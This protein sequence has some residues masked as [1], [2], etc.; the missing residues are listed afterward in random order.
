MSNKPEYIHLLSNAST[1]EFPENTLTNFK[2]SFPLPLN[3]D[4]KYEVGVIEFG[5]S[6][7]YGNI[8]IPKDKSIPSIIVTKCDL[9]K[10]PTCTRNNTPNC[11]EEIDYAKYYFEFHSDTLL[12]VEKRQNNKLECLQHTCKYNKYF[13]NSHNF[14]NA[15]LEIFQQRLLNDTGILFE[16]NNENKFEFKITEKFKISRH[17]N[18]NLYCWIM[19]HPTFAESFNF[20][21]DSIKLISDPDENLYDIYEVSMNGTKSIVH[22]VFYNGETYY[23]HF[24]SKK[25]NDTNPKYINNLISGIKSLE[26]KIYPHYIRIVSDNIRPQILDSKYSNDLVVF[27]PE[28]NESEEYFLRSI[29][30]IDYIP[31]LTNTLN[32][33]NIKLLDE[34][35]EQLQLA[36]GTA[37][38][39]KLA[40]KKMPK[41][42]ESF[43]IRLT[44]ETNL[45]FPD[46]N[47]SNF[48]VKLPTPLSFDETWK[49]SLNSISHPNKFA[50]FLQD[51]ESR[52]I[53]FED[54]SGSIG[55]IGNIY[56]HVFNSD[57]I[58]TEQEL[59]DELNLFLKERQI[60]YISRETRRIKI[61]LTAQGLF[62]MP[63]YVAKIF[64]FIPN[65]TDGSYDIKGAKFYKI[66]A[67][68]RY[69]LNNIIFKHE[70]E[71]T[72]DEKTNSKIRDERSIL[73]RPSTNNLAIFSP[74]E[75]VNLSLKSNYI[76]KIEEIVKILSD[77]FRN[78]NIGDCYISNEKFK[79]NIIAK[80][81]LVIGSSLAKVLGYNITDN[82]PRKFDSRDNSY[83]AVNSTI[84]NR[85]TKEAEGL[86]DI[87]LLRPS[88]MLIYSNIVKSNIVGGEY[89]KLLRLSPIKQMEQNYSITEFEH[90][91]FY[92]LETHEINIVEIALC[93]HDGEPIN[94]NSSKPVIVNLEFSNYEDL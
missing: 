71:N 42:K 88:Y 4:E 37:T 77:F 83:L 74:S 73:F 48:K 21:F 80:G 89:S 60:G 81:I 10:E 15:E 13:I 25:L 30:N 16:K 87:N 55:P 94:F 6:L 17:E 68:N 85:I 91:E 50:T 24:I 57:Y 46:N 8:K 41:G 26:N 53:T 32:N 75:T 34:N 47:Q 54:L 78:N 69:D 70:N 2:N 5:F 59:T 66:I 44:S 28:F 84:N 92:E 93:A 56:K 35:N 76:Y 29:K 27:T 20:T 18:P 3:I 52:Q 36:E 14:T 23:A 1:K 86:M 33:F 82:L 11:I 65:R 90:K 7:K 51:I 31:L 39:I 72:N 58:Y 64:G 43:N 61:T 67:E 38:V 12:C 9:L 79:I 22:K 19:L 49:V 63:K 40:L 62:R 45:L